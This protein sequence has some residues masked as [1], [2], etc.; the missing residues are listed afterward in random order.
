MKYIFLVMVLLILV[1]GC[2]GQECAVSE[3]CQLSLCDC[4][5]HLFGETPE[6][7]TG[8][9]CG[10]NCLGEYG[11]SGCECISGKCTEVIE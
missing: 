6:E 10:I 4:K 1:S 8:V 11:V 9:L 7:K 2:I 5:C 3:D